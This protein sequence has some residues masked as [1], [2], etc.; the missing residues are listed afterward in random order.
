MGYRVNSEN[1]IFFSYNFYHFSLKVIFISIIPY[2]V[3]KG[4][5]I[6]SFS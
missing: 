3:S 4:I 5:K 6:A 2:L 1:I